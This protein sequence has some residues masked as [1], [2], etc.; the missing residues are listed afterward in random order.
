MLFNSQYTKLLF[1]HIINKK[2][3][4]WHFNSLSLSSS[5]PTKPSQS[6]RFYIYS[7]SQFGLVTFQVFD[8]HQRLV[9]ALVDS[10]SLKGDNSKSYHIPGMRNT[11]QSWKAEKEMEDNLK[12]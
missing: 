11:Q 12:E 3:L 5:P 1:Q 7:T 10:T 8:G 4:R 9:A 2:L 6:A